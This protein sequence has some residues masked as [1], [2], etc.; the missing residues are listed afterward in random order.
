MCCSSIIEL[1]FVG[2]QLRMA[3][4]LLQ[5]GL[6]ANN[7][8][9]VV[10]PLRLCAPLLQCPVVT[11][12]RHAVNSHGDVRWLGERNWAGVHTRCVGHGKNCLEDVR[13]VG[14]ACLLVS[15]QLITSRRPGL[16]RWVDDGTAANGAPLVF[17]RRVV[18]SHVH[19]L[20]ATT[21]LKAY[22]A[23]SGDGIER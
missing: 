10:R 19:A 11:N 22:C 7:D 4:A 3:V 5:S 13:F 8:T 18:V 9:L 2:P 14:V 21:L 15:L 23:N 1:G 16:G 17:L 12:Y 20:E 6:A